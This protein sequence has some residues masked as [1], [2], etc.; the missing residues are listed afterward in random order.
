MKVLKHLRE[1]W[2]IYTFVLG[3]LGLALNQYMRFVS[4]EAKAN[5]LAER[6]PVVQELQ[7]QQEVQKVKLD[8]ID[9][10]VKEIRSDVKEIRNALLKK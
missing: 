7:T 6:I 10:N 2:Q 9:S 1:N 4:L 8:N 5:D 3:A